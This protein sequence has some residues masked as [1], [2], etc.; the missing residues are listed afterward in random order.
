[1]QQYKY[2]LAPLF[3]YIVAH[4]LK[5][6]VSNEKDS[7]FSNKIFRSGG[8]PSAHTAFTVALCTLIALNQGL[9]SVNF[10]IMLA[11]TAIV[12]YDAV[13]ARRS[14]GDYGDVIKSLLANKNS[15]KIKIHYSKGHSIAEVIVGIICGI[16]VGLIAQYIF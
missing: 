8:M 3:A 4:I 5:F 15:P 13:N 9:D 10:A 12:M 7:S 2:L 6:L 14:V 16:A 1:M 11:F